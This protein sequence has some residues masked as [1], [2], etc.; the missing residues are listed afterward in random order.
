MQRLRRVD[1][2]VLAQG[3]AAAGGAA[4]GGGERAR[5]FARRFSSTRTRRAALANLF[6]M[7]SRSTLFASA[8]ATAVRSRMVAVVAAICFVLGQ[9]STNRR[10]ARRWAS[11][12]LGAARDDIL[13]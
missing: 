3:V 12:C 7:T 5:A 11:G 10:Q 2:P 13:G 6:A 8:A 9:P 1:W 4:R